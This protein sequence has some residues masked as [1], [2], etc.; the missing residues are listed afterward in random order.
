MKAKNMVFTKQEL[1]LNQAPLFNFEL[2]KNELLELALN[3]GFV[4]EISTDQYK[5]NQNYGE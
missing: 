3:R 4:S 5:I 1:W 2:D